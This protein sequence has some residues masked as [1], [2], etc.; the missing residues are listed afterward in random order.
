MTTKDDSGRRRWP[1]IVA[2]V[3]IA[4]L[5]IAYLIFTSGGFLEPRIESVLT[6]RLDAR[7]RVE[8]LDF[9]LFGGT[10][11]EQ[12]SLSVES[13]G[14]EGKSSRLV[15][16]DCLIEHDVSA[17]LTGNY[18]MDRLRVARMD[19]DVKPGLT[20]WIERLR[21]GPG[22]EGA[23]GTLPDVEIDEGTVRVA[24]PSLPRPLRLDNLSLLLGSTRP[25]RLSGVVSFRVGGNR[26]RL[27]ITAAPSQ[28]Y[29]DVNVMI[30]GFDLQ[31]IPQIPRGTDLFDPSKLFMNGA[32]TGQLSVPLG[33]DSVPPFSGQ[34]SLAESSVAYS[35]WPLE[36]TNLSAQVQL[37]Q[38]GISLSNIKTNIGRGRVVITTA[39]VRLDG[40]EVESV[41]LR[42]TARELNLENL[43]HGSVPWSTLTRGDWGRIY[44]GSLD[45][46]FNLQWAPDSKPSYEAD[47]RLRDGSL[48]VERLDRR[49]DGVNVA[50]TINSGGL[51]SID[52]ARIPVA[53]GEVEASGSLQLVD[54]EV[55]DPRLSLRLAELNPTPELM[56][57]LHPSMEEILQ[58]VKLENPS[59]S[60]DVTVSPDDVSCEL[61]IAAREVEPVGVPYQFTDFSTDLH[62][63]SSGSVIRFRNISAHRNGGQVEGDVSAN[64]SGRPTLEATIFGRALPINDELVE[65][66]PAD[67][68][69]RVRRW[70]PEGKFDFEVRCQNWQMPES[71]CTKAIRGVAVTVD[72]RDI[73]LSYPGFPSLVHN[74]YGHISLRDGIVKL[75]DVN[76]QI[77]DAS[78]RVNGSVPLPGVEGSTTLRLETE[79]VNVDPDSLGALPG[80][81][82]KTLAEMKGQGQLA[83]RAD[84]SQFPTE[85]QP[86]KASGSAVIHSFE[87]SPKTMHLRASGTSRVTAEWQPGEPADVSGTVRLREA[88]TSR[89]SADRVSARFEYND[90]ILTMPA[91]NVDAY[92]GKITAKNTH[93]NTI[94]GG[95]ETEVEYAHMD[96][97]SLMGAFDIRGEE[98]PGGVLRGRLE[99]SGTRMNPETFT[100]TGQLR[101]DRGR[102]Y[103]FPVLLSVFSVLDLG[104]PSQSPVSDALGNYKMN[105]GVLTIEDLVFSGGG[106]MPV[107]ITGTVSLE[108]GVKFKNR[109]IN[110]LVT[111]AKRPGLLDA[112]PVIGFIKHYTIDLLRRFIMQA[113]V[114]GT[115][116][117][118]QVSTIA[119][120][121]TRPIQAIWSL[122]PKLNPMDSGKKGTSTLPPALQDEVER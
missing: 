113:R 34:F 77:L 22:G 93:F 7:T 102:L 64:L 106:G 46:D 32:L 81:L 39:R 30:H 94:T 76:G 41:S 27:N 78:A 5:G 99:V 31:A 108:E 85:E 36:L 97:E 74:L 51:V 71:F 65:L 48:Q 60:G 89:I 98:A 4:A 10:T 18:V 104:L 16:E 72:L 66:F 116:A 56:G 115:F 61:G 75:T 95:W 35:G 63:S 112:I 57:Q 53:G 19:A 70:Q 47:V 26:I 13:G 33:A 17:L 92:G 44:S 43:T 20:D 110:M 15:F 80:E 79:T 122:V 67:L 59:V 69:D 38:N 118:Y 23:D 40:A 3:G 105:D 11:V 29:G 21:E 73:S 49:L 84:V 120:P 83:L 62:W 45:A 28:G 25:G 54:G 96:L 88:E 50:A 121:V 58:R 111:V 24:D 103:S 107:H 82:G 8:G 55:R 109:K 119:D 9:G 14:P 90:T 101:I 86:L 1:W 87:L 6:E 2:G 117:D 12:I 37:T 52:S 68:R 91:F 42:G 114:T 100:G